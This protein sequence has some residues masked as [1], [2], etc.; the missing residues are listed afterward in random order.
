MR[1]RGMRENVVVLVNMDADA[2]ARVVDRT[3][4]KHIVRHSGPCSLC[5]AVYAMRGCPQGEDENGGRCSESE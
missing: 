5:H 3:V 2:D 1:R 4:R